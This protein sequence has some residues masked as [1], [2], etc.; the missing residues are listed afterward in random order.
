V[1]AA[2]AQGPAWLVENEVS[3]LLTAPEDANALAGAVG[4]VLGETGLAGRLA[5]AGREAHRARFSEPAV[6]E[7]YIE[8]F[9]K[10]VR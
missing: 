2:A 3:G 1:V 4:R 9:D 10:V 8:L 6:V 7:R 5:D